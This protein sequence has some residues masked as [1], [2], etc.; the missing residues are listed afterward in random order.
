VDVLD[1][2]D[3]FNLTC[4]AKS[5]PVLAKEE[6]MVASL[7]CVLRLSVPRVTTLFAVALNWIAVVTLAETL[8]VDTAIA[9]NWIAVVRLVCVD[10]LEFTTD[11]NLILLVKLA[12]TLLEHTAIAESS[13][14][15]PLPVDDIGLELIGKNPSMLSL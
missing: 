4:V 13:A 7:I 11:V 8:T 5:A 2:T 12:S 3:V 6:A 10:V 9:E 1:D 14:D 15:G